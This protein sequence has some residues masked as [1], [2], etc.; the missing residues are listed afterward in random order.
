MKCIYLRV[1]IY[2]YIIKYMA[3]SKQ[4]PSKKSKKVHILVTIPQKTFEAIAKAK[5]ERGLLTDQDVIRI[6]ISHFLKASGYDI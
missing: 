3:T 6:S 2:R 5:A 4:T 1:H